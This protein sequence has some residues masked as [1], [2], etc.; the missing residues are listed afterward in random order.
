MK[1]NKILASW[2]ID[3]IEQKMCMNNNEFIDALI[4]TAGNYTTNVTW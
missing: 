4:N 2:K 3:S 1:T